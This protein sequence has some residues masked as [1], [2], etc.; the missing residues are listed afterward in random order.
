MPE[1]PVNYLLPRQKLIE[2]A[3]ITKNIIIENESDIS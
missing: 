3:D 2:L 1:E